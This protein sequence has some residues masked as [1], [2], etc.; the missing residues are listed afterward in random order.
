MKFVLLFGVLLV[1]LFSYSSAEMLDDFDQADEDELLSLIE[2]EEARAKECTPRF[3]D[4]SHDRHSCCRS[5]LFKDVCTCFYPEGGDN[6]VCTCQ[7]PKHLK[8]MEKAADKAKK[9]GGKIK[10]WFG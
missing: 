2:K 6:E 3:Y 7:Q 8:Y 5:E 9:F 1:T 4:C 10:K